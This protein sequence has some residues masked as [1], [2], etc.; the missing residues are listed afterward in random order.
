M[1]TFDQNVTTIRQAQYG[2]QVRD[3]IAE[4]LEYLDGKTVPGRCENFEV[5]DDSGSQSQNSIVTIK[6]PKFNATTGTLLYNTVYID[7]AYN[8][9]GYYYARIRS[10]TNISKENC[11]WCGRRF[12]KNMTKSVLY[13]KDDDTVQVILK[14][15]LDS[16]ETRETI[17]KVGY[18]GIIVSVNIYSD[19]ELSS[20]LGNF[21]EF[22]LGDCTSFNGYSKFK[23]YV[24]TIS[25]IKS[26]TF[27][28]K[29]ASFGKVQNLGVISS[30]SNFSCDGTS[31][32][33]DLQTTGY[34]GVAA[35]FYIYF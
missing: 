6:I 4:G 15:S 21:T 30:S 16:G 8:E 12:S 11:V 31:F 35:Q 34:L 32:Y 5:A 23:T 7:T 19:V 10:T 14:D 28:F 9:S 3:A 13:N 25:G 29:S 2:Y 24:G 17:I 33:R 27:P 22:V 18:T 26:I 20:G 1:A